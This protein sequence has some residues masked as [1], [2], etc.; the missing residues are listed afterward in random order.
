MVEL[1]Y[2]QDLKSCGRKT[3]RVR[4]PFP[5]HM[6]Y[7]YILKSLKKDN[8]HYVGSCRDLE[9][10]F[11]RHF[12][13]LVRSTKGYRPLEIMYTEKFEKYTDARRREGYLKSKG[14]YLEKRKILEQF[15]KY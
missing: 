5:A 10:R 9:A 2:T 1:V 15:D 6:A 11:D 8:W 4:V 14:G 3:L 12:R 13:G 7:M